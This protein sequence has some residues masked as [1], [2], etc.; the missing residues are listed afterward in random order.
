M[1]VTTQFAKILVES[2]SQGVSYKKTL[3]LGRQNL[4]LFADF[5][6]LQL[7]LHEHNC[8]PKD[9]SSAEF[10]RRI[11]G[12]DYVDPFLE[13]LGAEKVDSLDNSNY[14]GASILHDLDRKV[15]PEWHQ[16]YDCI[17]D[18]GLLEHVFNFPTAIQSCMEMTRCG[19]HVI[20][21]TT[22]NNFMGHGFYQ[23]SPE[24][25]FRIFS[26]ENGF[27]MVRMLVQEED[28]IMTAAL[29]QPIRI[30]QVGPRYE[31]TDPAMIGQR[32]ELVN[33]HPAVMYVVAK[34]TKI[35]PIFTTSPK[36]SD[37]VAAWNRGGWDKPPAETLRKP[38]YQ[39]PFWRRVLARLIGAVTTEPQ[40][41]KL[42]LLVLRKLRKTVEKRKLKQWY[43]SN[44][45]HNE[46]FF[47]KTP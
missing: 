11:A 7:M 42:K 9:L 34:R 10:H 31:I 41:T 37:Y 18:G 27:E 2:R 39:P 29:G 13:M 21:F 24:L 22:A 44:S 28:L 19:G 47:K 26:P 32:V 30:D 6:Q 40:R 20:L 23:F 25:F 15:P 35:V 33:S 8:W 45:L 4:P 17:I 38:V 12:S 43:Q 1:G 3:T 5:E 36:Q 16:S 46:K 14:E